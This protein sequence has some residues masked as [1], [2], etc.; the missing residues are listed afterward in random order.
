MIFV[1]Y[2]ENGYTYTNPVKFTTFSDGARTVK[3]HIPKNCKIIN[4]T[5]S[6][7]TNVSLVLDSLMLIASAIRELI[8]NPVIHLNLEYLPY[9]RADR[10]FEEGNPNPLKMFIKFIEFLDFKEVTVRDPHNEHCLPDWIVIS[11]EVGFNYMMSSN[12]IE[13]KD[14]ILVAPDK[15][16]VDKIK[17][18]GVDRIIYGD[19]TRDVSTGKITNI[20]IKDSDIDV[21]GK[22][23]VIVDD[24]C[25]GG[26][27]FI[28]LAGQLKEQ[29]ADKVILY[30]THGIFSKGLGIFEK[31]IDKILCYNIV[32]HF[33]TEC[34]IENFNNREYMI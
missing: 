12:D 31:N 28:P 22:T 23:V 13:L 8:E 32:S 30:V 6:S 9:G 33:V 2:V 18:I 25:D 3:I 27:T 21:K 34:D 16:A 24:I 1:T 11:Q 7:K 10:V 26:G 20:F 4:I 17:R 5:V 15:G 29:G 14:I 19:K